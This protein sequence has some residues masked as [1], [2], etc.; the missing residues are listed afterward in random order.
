M[1][2]LKAFLDCLIKP[3][4]R[5]VSLFF[6]SNLFI[7]ISYVL[8]DGVK[9]FVGRLMYS[10]LSIMQSFALG[11]VCTYALF[12]VAKLLDKFHN[13]IGDV[14]RIM[15]FVT[16]FLLSFINV[17]LR[18][19]FHLELHYFA[20]VLL[21]ETNPSESSEFLSQYLLSPAL[22]WSVLFLA[23]LPFMVH[24]LFI[25]CRH[26]C[27]GQNLSHSLIRYIGGTIILMCFMILPSMMQ[28]MGVPYGHKY[29]KCPFCKN[30][31]FL[32]YNGIGM[33]NANE[34]E[35]AECIEQCRNVNDISSDF[36]SPNIVLIIGE[37]YNRHHA[38]LYGYKH[39]TTSPLDTIRDLT[40]FSDV[41]T[42]VNSTARAFR[43][44]FSTVENTPERKWCD[45]PTF[46]A[47]F[48]AAG[49]DVNF[50]TTQ[51]PYGA[52]MDMN[53][54]NAAYFN[55]A[56][57]SELC[58]SHRNLAVCKY[59][60]ELI[61]D[62]IEH[63]NEIEIGK[64]TLSIFHLYGQHVGPSER[65]PEGYGAFNVEDYTERKLPVDQLQHIA[66]YDNATLYNSEQ[67]LRIIDIFREKDAVI[68][69]FADHGD[70]VNDFRPH[71]GRAFDFPGNG[72]E[73][74]H[75]QFDIPFMVYMT[76]Q[77]VENHPVIAQ[78]MQDA[79]D[80]PYST[81]ALSHLM[82]Y[83]AGIH[84]KWYN[85]NLNPLSKMYNRKYRLIYNG[86]SYTYHSYEELCHR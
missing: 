43:L 53:N 62:Y 82:F 13:Y 85:Q 80:K 39:P 19:S 54:S 59:D 60:E 38:S 69:Y 12:G 15:T 16:A 11:F 48:K 10:P 41:I 46:P 3:L 17:F 75:C 64:P 23:V 84:T 45:G 4:Q 58:F 78:E 76:K 42:P 2:Y 51:F 79:K 74:V 70:E 77:Y 14:V 40:I 30:P 67:I 57:L 8:L 6:Y 29:N 37:S 66:D 28:Y 33:Y 36:T 27:Y 34:P 47:I 7:F 71:V 52:T 1:I 81:D 63:R 65:F 68:I 72:A 31:I 20:L 44:F 21:H 50:W 25:K 26:F 24:L 18:F 56:E 83:L 22:I 32:L 55:K 35:I 5:K 73:V 49:Y 61:D 9:Q 86:T